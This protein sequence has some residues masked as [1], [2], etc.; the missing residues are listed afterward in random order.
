MADVIKSRNEVLALSGLLVV[1]GMA[2][3]LSGLSNKGGGGGASDEF[4]KLAAVHPDETVGVPTVAGIGTGVLPVQIG[5]PF[6]LVN[7]TVSYAGPG[8]DT[9]THMRVV[10][11][12]N[13]HWITVYGT[14]VG[15]V[16]VGPSNEVRNFALI[17]PDEL[18]PPGCPPQSLCAF[19]WPGAE[20]SPINGAPADLG[21]ATVL[22]E[23]YQ[24]SQQSGNP[25][26]ADGF[27]SPT[28]NNRIPIRRSAFRDAVLFT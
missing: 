18:Q 4:G 23:I 13:S 26:D 9:Y 14:G 11:F 27:S 24:N 22:L 25:A 3:V 1:G 15:G 17:S 28:Y 7:P 16:H 2:L 6:A 8:R 21:K 19:P 20:V 5:Q 10:Q 12:R